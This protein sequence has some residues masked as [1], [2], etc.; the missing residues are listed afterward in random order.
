MT[1]NRRI[2][3]VVLP[4]CHVTLRGHKPLPPGYP[5]SLKT[6]GDHIRKR[7][8]DLKLTQKEVA[9][10]IGV[11]KTTI[12]FWEKNRVKPSLAQIPKIIEFLGRDPFE[13]KAESLGDKIKTYRRIHG[14]SQKKLAHLVGIDP[15]TVG[16]WE[17]GKNRPV[18]ENLK[19][20]LLILGA[21]S[22]FLEHDR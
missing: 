8:L 19:K 13:A 6:I 7:R 12:Q 17:K 1:S 14:F 20:L 18:K 10:R 16:A 4:F 9:E 15:S 21:D 11:D 3:T 2:G 22:S 5:K